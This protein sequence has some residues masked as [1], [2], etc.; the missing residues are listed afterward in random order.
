MWGKVTFRA[1]GAYYE[2]FINELFDSGIRV[3]SIRSEKN[4]VY[5]DIN[6]MFYPYAA[7]LSRKYGLRVRITSKKGVKFRTAGVM[8]RPGLIIGILASVFTVLTLRLFVWDIRFHGNEE[9]SNDYMLRLLE[10]YGFTAGV[11]ANDTDALNAERHILLD[12]DRIRWINIE[13]NGS[14]ADVYMKE[15]TVGDKPDVDPKTPC[16]IIASHSGVIV[17]TDV[18]SGKLMYTKGSGVAKGS[19]I[20]S[21]AVSSGDSLILVHSDAEIIADFTENA[22]FAMDRTTS[23]KVPSDEKFTHRQ[24]MFLGMVIPLDGNDSDTSDTVCDEY[25]EQ[26]KLFGFDLPLK[27]RT[28]NYRRYREISVTRKDEDIR[29]ILEQQLEQYINN[30]LKEYEVRDIEKTFKETENGLSLDAVISL[31]GNIAVK[32]PIYEHSSDT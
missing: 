14:R 24:L 15:N 17:E 3:G 21:G 28:E 4:A 18:S 22:K 10:Q 29:R 6:A 16:N 31:R 30:F 19:V 9:L 7:K 32:N 12:S 1:V 5:M 25:T 26:I 27:V 8:K 20:V 2:P 11:L 23:E 13:V